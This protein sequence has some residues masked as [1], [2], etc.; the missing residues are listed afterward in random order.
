[1]TARALIITRLQFAQFI[2]LHTTISDLP[3]DMASLPTSAIKKRSRNS[4][5]NVSEKLMME[6]QALIAFASYDSPSINCGGI[7]MSEATME[8]I[9]TKLCFGGDTDSN[10]I[11]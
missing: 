10:N 4:G 7:S 8:K 3:P 6:F 9:M 5:T 2:H 1:M 11:S